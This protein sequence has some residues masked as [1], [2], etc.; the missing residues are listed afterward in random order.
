MPS[1]G[2][3]R[4]PFRARN[5]LMPVQWTI[6][7]T[8]CLV[9]AASGASFGQAKT[10]AAAATARRPLVIFRELPLARQRLDAQSLPDA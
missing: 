10:F 7:P 5:S 9:V 2:P 8:D 4:H 1:Q 6:S 3:A